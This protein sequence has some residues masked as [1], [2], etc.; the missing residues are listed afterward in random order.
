MD[1]KNLLAA[2]KSGSEEG[3]RTLVDLYQTKVLNICLGYFPIHQDAEDLVQEVF[4]KLFSSVQQFRGEASLGTWVYRITVNKCLEM[5]RYRKRTKRMAFFQSLVGIDE[6]AMQVSS[7]QFDHPGV[8]L[9]NKERTQLLYQHIE[10][11]PE[12]QRT[13]F[14]LSRLEGLS[15]QE[16]C[17]IMELSLSSVESLLFRA[18]NNLKKTLRHYYEKQMI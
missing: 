17:T 5:V 18:K 15:Y 14:I 1:E 8:T 13:A 12:K 16:I 2:L 6:Q 3:Y 11:L 4:V 9:E 10:K 7:G